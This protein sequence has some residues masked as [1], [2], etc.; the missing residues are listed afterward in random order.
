MIEDDK[1]DEND[2]VVGC[3]IVAWESGW[4]H[5]SS[6]YLRIGTLQGKQVV[7]VCN[8]N[9]TTVQVMSVLVLFM[10]RGFVSGKTVR[11]ITKQLV[12]SP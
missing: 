3:A 1:N 2:K 5:G 12:T 8:L 9:S 10:Y 6:P 4:S 11:A 7:L